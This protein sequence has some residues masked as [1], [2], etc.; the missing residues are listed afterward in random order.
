MTRWNRVLPLLVAAVL[1]AAP[2]MAQDRANIQTSAELTYTGQVFSDVA[3]SIDRIYAI[4]QMGLWVFTDNPNFMTAHEDSLSLEA[5]LTDI[6]YNEYGYTDNETAYVGTEDG[7]ILVVSTGTSTT[8]ELTVQQTINVGTGITLML[9]DYQTMVVFDSTEGLVVYDIA[10][11]PANPTELSRISLSGVVT[12]GYYSGY[13]YYE[14]G[15]TFYGRSMS[16]PSSP[17]SEFTYADLQVRALTEAGGDFFVAIQDTILRALP[18][19]YA[20]SDSLD[21]DTLDAMIHGMDADDAYPMRVFLATEN[22]LRVYMD[23]SGGGDPVMEAAGHLNTQTAAHFVHFNDDSY[24]NEFFAGGDGFIGIYSFDETLDV[25]EEGAGALP[26][27]FTLADPY[28][29]PFNPELT[30]P[31]SVPDAGEVRITL[32]NT[33][34]REV[35]SLERTV[36]PG[37]HRMMLSPDGAFASGVY[38]LR[39]QYDGQSRV[40][41]VVRLR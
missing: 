31:F 40:R 38:L 19:L 15:G 26:E 5:M 35:A 16:D 18:D 12:E 6:V 10:T 23:A 2:A 33:L 8:D 39:V 34:G 4:S 13:L 7:D 3:V 24:S 37:S 30:V 1:L 20:N 14:I 36:A 21:Q 11:D 17:G 32:V 28:P 41:R 27:R 22:G 9:K 25:P 29:N